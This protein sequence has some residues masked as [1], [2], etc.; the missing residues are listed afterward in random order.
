MN[1]DTVFS[2]LM[3]AA[4]PAAVAYPLI[5]GLLAPWHRS[6]IGRALMV[7]AVGIAILITFS[8]LFQILGPSY[9]GRDIIRI[10]GMCFVCVG[11]WLVLPLLLSQVLPRKR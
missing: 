7:K 8:A 1:T 10:T 4:W 9:P 3:I 6:W 11:V 2:V 5:Y